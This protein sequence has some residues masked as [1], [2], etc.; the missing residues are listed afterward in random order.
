MFAVLGATGTEESPEADVVRGIATALSVMVS[1]STPN[2]SASDGVTL[3][4]D[5]GSATALIDV[6][7][8][9]TSPSASQ[10]VSSNEAPV[11][12]IKTESGYAKPPRLF[13]KRMDQLVACVS[14]G[15]S[16]R[17]SV[18]P[19]LSAGS[20][21]EPLRLT[22]YPC[23]PV[24]YGRARSA[25]AHP[26]VAYSSYPAFSEVARVATTP[27]DDDSDIEYLSQSEEATRSDLNRSLGNRKSIMAAYAFRTVGYS[28]QTI[29][30]MAPLT[31]VPQS[32]F[33]IGLP[34]RPAG[35]PVPWSPLGPSVLYDLM[36]SLPDEI[37]YGGGQRVI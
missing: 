15:R 32:L 29:V 23:N 31:A 4:A 16:R 5:L 28:S 11:P 37:I 10:P 6:P 9:M 26:G 8:S 17:H 22:R 27:A 13:V 34:G 19:H 2:E 12:A 21:F 24:Y 33:A 30:P 25:P 35:S 1:Q 18:Y 20:T 7:G 3:N 36:S 14:Q